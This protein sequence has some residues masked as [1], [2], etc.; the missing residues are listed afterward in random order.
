METTVITVYIENKPYRFN[1]AVDHEEQKT[2]YYVDS[3]Q[4]E[5]YIPQTLEFNENG[6][7][8]EKF[9]LKTVEQEQIARLVWQEII[10]KIK[11]Q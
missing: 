1:V 2:T 9:A 5:D 3:E 11:P 6:K 8:S 4:H 7:V 10:N